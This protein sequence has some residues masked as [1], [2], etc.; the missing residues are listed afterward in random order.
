[1]C[2]RSE[3]KSGID[4]FIFSFK[5]EISRDLGEGNVSNP[6]ERLAKRPDVVYKTI[7]RDF[8][9]FYVTMLHQDSGM[10]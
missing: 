7:L 10:P 3:E 5:S 1:M 9:R 2:E 6:K 4:E 8:R